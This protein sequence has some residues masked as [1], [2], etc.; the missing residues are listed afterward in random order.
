[1]CG[2]LGAYDEGA[3]LP[4]EKAIG[5]YKQSKVIAQRLVLDMVRERGLPAIVVN[6]ST[7]VGPRDIRSTPAA[8]PVATT[9][10]NRTATDSGSSPKPLSTNTEAKPVATASPKVVSKPNPPPH[11]GPNPP[12]HAATAAAHPA[13]PAVAKRGPPPKRPPA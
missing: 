7:P 10:S 3:N 6:P 9:P 12:P 11:A 4:I 5:A 2:R 1:M 13:V 8:K